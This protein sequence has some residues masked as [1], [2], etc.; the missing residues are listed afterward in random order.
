MA[1]TNAAGK[2]YLDNGNSTGA[3]LQ[4][5]L[6]AEGDTEGVGYGTGAGSTVTQATSI[7]T[8]VTINKVC[9]TITT[10]SST[11][12]TGADATFT[13]TNSTVAATDVVIASIKSYGGTADGIPTVHVSATAAGSFDVNI[14]NQGATTLDAVIVIN[15][16]VIKAVAA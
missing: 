13:V 6:L 1:N 14:R 9:G 4:G 8:G 7:T 12:G 10:V 11:L 5:G 3:Y 15:F 16:A 2:Q